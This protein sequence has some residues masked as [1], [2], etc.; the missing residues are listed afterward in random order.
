M[1]LLL[2]PVVDLLRSRRLPSNLPQV[3]KIRAI[4][5]QPLLHRPHP[6]LVPK[7]SEFIH[8]FPLIEDKF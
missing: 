6:H 4:H 2:L 5:L 3:V 8:V 7:T 1:P